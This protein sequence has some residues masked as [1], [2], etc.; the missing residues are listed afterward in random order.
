MSALAYQKELNLS[1]LTDERKVLDVV[2]GYANGG[3]HFVVDEVINIPG[4]PLNN[5]IELIIQ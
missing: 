2:Q 3:I 1:I 4:R 5:L